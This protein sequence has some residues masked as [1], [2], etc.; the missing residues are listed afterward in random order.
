MKYVIVYVYL[1][2]ESFNYVILEMV[3]S[4]L[5]GKGYE[6]CVCD[7]YELNFNLVLG[8]FDFILFF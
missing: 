8:V 4:E 3:K 7:L 5:E 1:N 2:I 6:V